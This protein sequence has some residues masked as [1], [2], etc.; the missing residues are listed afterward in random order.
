MRGKKNRL[1][2][3]RIEIKEGIVEGDKVAYIELHPQLGSRIHHTWIPHNIWLVE[4]KFGPPVAHW[5]IHLFH[6]KRENV[7]I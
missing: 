7:Y 1:E 3:P 5:M 6:R 4:P 2:E